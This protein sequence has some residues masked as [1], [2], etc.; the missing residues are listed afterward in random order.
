MDIFQISQTSVS[1]AA[2]QLRYQQDIHKGIYAA[3]SLQ[4][5]PK[6]VDPPTT[7]VALTNISTQAM[8]HGYFTQI[9]VMLYLF[10]LLVSI[11][12]NK[13]SRNFDIFRTRTLYKIA[14]K[15]TIWKRE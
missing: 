10:E 8:I 2:E 1:Y 9:K 12:R 3:L 14:M 11:Y 7:R 4:P 6:L 13:D 15:A 5:S